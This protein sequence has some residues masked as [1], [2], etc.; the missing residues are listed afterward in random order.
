MVSFR[1]TLSLPRHGRL[2]NEEANKMSSPLSKPSSYDL[3]YHPQT[4]GLFPRSFS[5]LDYALYKIQTLFLSFCPKRYSRPL[6]RLKSKG[7]S[8]RRALLHFFVCFFLGIFVG[9][10]PFGSPTFSMHLIA[11]HQAFS[12]EMLQQ[13]DRIR[14]YDLSRN[15]TPNP[16]GTIHELKDGILISSQNNQSY[17]QEAN[18]SFDKLLI[19]ATPIHARS[20]Q[21]Y[22]LN[23]LAQTLKLVR[24]PL[25]WIIVEM[26]SQ[27]VE[28]AKLLRNSGV[29]YRHLI[30]KDIVTEIEDRGM[31]LRNVALSHIEKHQIDGIVYFADDH[32]IYT[33]DLFDQ[34][35]QIRRFGTWK[36]AKLRERKTDFV[37]EGPICNG[38]QVMGWHTNDLT[39]KFQRFHVAVSGFAFHST[40]LWDPKRWHQSTLEPIRLLHTIKE[41]FQVS[42]FVE[43]IVDDESQMQGKEKASKSSVLKKFIPDWSLT[44]NDLAGYMKNA[45]EFLEYAFP[46]RDATIVEECL[47]QKFV[48]RGAL[49]LITGSVS[50][51]NLLIRWE[52]DR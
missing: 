42:M 5:S 31:H 41:S 1:R 36:V 46:P 8:W 45:L 13:V 20:F 29:M 39:N 38:S 7:N 37:I 19:V 10:T 32:N 4:G 44:T 34:M 24:P 6:E 22:Y 48:A 15:V 40:I 9:L 2:V 21:A 27:S 51:H 12:F 25:L 35:R 17:N 28:I 47:D 14:F 16:E 11:K 50:Y 23:R 30:C 49:D 26:K 43:Q 52:E 33:I 18:M 3:S